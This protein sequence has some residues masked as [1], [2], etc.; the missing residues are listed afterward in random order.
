MYDEHLS[1]T[2]TAAAR[3][4][5]AVDGLHD[6]VIALDEQGRL[7]YVNQAARNLLKVDVRD[8]PV[9]Y[10]QA[11]SDVSFARAIEQAMPH[12]TPDE[13]AAAGRINEFMWSVNRVPY[14]VRVRPV[15][16]GYLVSFVREPGGT[17]YRER[18]ENEHTR[19]YLATALAGI[20]SWT[21]DLE[22]NKLTSDSILAELTDET[23]DDT[24]PATDM[25]SHIHPDD[26]PKVEAVIER[27]ILSTDDD[28]DDADIDVMFRFLTDDGE[29]IWLAMRG[30]VVRDAA[31]KPLLLSGVHFDVTD[32]KRAEQSIVQ[33][34]EAL[35]QANRAKDSFLA[36]VSHEIRTPLTAILG[37]AELM[38]RRAVKSQDRKDL[39]EIIDSA[40]YLQSLVDDLLDL[41][42]VI[43]GKVT[44]EPEPIDIR[45]LGH[46]LLSTMNMRAAEKGLGFSLNVGPKVPTRTLSD[47]VR[48][49]QILMNLV[50][51]AVKFTD[52]GEVSVTIKAREIGRQPFIAF[53]V[54]DTGPG[55]DNE[56][57]DE[58][59]QPF[60]QAAT[61]A[62]GRHGG[63][64]LGLAISQRI[65][66]VLG[67]TIKVE[68]EVNAGSTFTFL[69]PVENVEDHIEHIKNQGNERDPA[70]GERPR[71]RTD[72]RGKVLVVDDVQ[73]IL[74]LIEQY[75]SDAGA[76][77]VTASNGIE[78][79]ERVEDLS[80]RGEELDVILMDLQMPHLDGRETLQ[81]LREAGLQT[82]VIALTA[83]AMK[84]ERERCMSWGFSEFISKPFEAE[85]LIEVVARVV[86][87]GVPLT[88]PSDG[89]ALPQTLLLV[90]DHESLA[91]ITAK[92]LASLGYTV[93]I[94]HTGTAAID[95]A[96]ALKPAA[97]VV[98][99]TLPDMEGTDVCRILLEDETLSNC[100]MIAYTGLEEPD[101][102]ARAQAAG[103]AGVL[104]KPAEIS[105]FAALL[106]AN[107]NAA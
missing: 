42:R 79:L 40:R 4:L 15:D 26:L 60:A 85:D 80:R 28:D 65:A 56:Q 1:P 105:D 52:E 97:M 69:L 55:I 75:L 100:R 107:P 58:L 72:I 74:A 78:A 10:S 22:T 17:T 21:W 89:A 16:N 44:I 50:G 53:E 29:Q 14:T 66:E 6:P 13:A 51:N 43:A 2:A 70:R 35:E 27:A 61:S 73:P 45:H 31:G 71:R 98:D 101:H 87:E 77:V 82:P 103:F 106:G 46:D 67:G 57:I 59:F 12:G 23:V 92:Q 24:M 37:Y 64:G 25:L 9:P 102:H 86:T 20:G 7:Y 104:I 8:L 11:L 39:D 91:D 63:V 36:K 19:R 81:R 76:D 68:S 90:E 93:E 54:I 32:A 99:L 38:A 95:R 3:V 33:A 5:E 49:R 34:K 88:A 47:P 48:V 41:S 83:S 84:G 94:A 96:K 18:L 62:S 30:G